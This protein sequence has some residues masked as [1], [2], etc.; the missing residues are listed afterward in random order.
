M[1]PLAGQLAPDPATNPDVINALDAKDWQRALS[2]AIAMGV[3]DENE[4]ANLIF[5]GKHPELPRAPLDT[6]NPKFQQLAAE[7]SQILNTEVWAAIQAASENT[8]LVVSGTEVK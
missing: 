5:F 7:W 8:A 6:K 2:L 4:L 3:R 1:P